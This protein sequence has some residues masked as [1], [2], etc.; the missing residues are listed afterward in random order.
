MNRDFE[1]LADRLF[2][3]TIEPA[4]EASS[5]PRRQPVHVVYGGAD[6]F[7]RDVATKFGRI[8]LQSVE[9][10]APD[11]ETFASAMGLRCDG[12]GKSIAPVLLA[13]VL[14]KL[15]TRPV[16]DFR[17]D[18]EDGYGLRRDEEEDS[19]AIGCANEFAAGMK[20]GSLPDFCG[21][22]IK[23]LQ[24]ETFGRSVRTL[25]LFLRTLCRLTS[26]ELPS[27][28]AVTLPKIR[29]ASEVGVLTEL[30]SELERGNGI[31]AGS[32]SIE[33]MVETPDILFELRKAVALGEGRVSAAHFGAY[34]YTG[35]LG[36]TADHQD[37]RHPSCEFARD[38]MQASLAPLGVR[39][40][41]SVT[42]EMP[43]PLH[44]GEGL[45]PEQAEANRAAVH[46]AW[47]RHFTNIRHSLS[48]GFYQS[49]DLHPAQLV[50][51]YAAL[52]AFFLE[53]AESQ[54]ERL[55]RFIS[56]ATKATMTGNLFDDAASAQGCLNFF[57][58]AISCGAITEDE[59][60]ELTGLSAEEILSG[61]FRKIMEGRS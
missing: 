4:A 15:R 33:L 41:D 21:I 28:F 22:R 58:R 23:S 13:R 9:S 46:G 59:A 20:G 35:N 57:V 24:P 14:A 12:A 10:F 60:S 31:A 36:I 38:F 2:R 39:L 34:D 56:M 52:T 54:G 11:A 43:V 45:T 37:L 8:A 1:E 51:R 44:R 32:I 40:S 6:R 25:E 42:T 61:S 48:R 53:S 47:Q 55:N 17:A 3:D 50:A 30:I 5:T 16:E 29:S 26:G 49:W 7:T 27:G 19:H 18:F